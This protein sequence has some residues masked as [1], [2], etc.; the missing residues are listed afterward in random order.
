LVGKY[1][2]DRYVGAISLDSQS[3]PLI[4]AA[5]LKANEFPEN[6]EN[7]TASRTRTHMSPKVK[8]A[9]EREKGEFPQP[10]ELST[11]K[12]GLKRAILTFSWLFLN[13]RRLSQRFSS[14]V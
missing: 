5:N 13:S 9:V 3:R 12:R 8:R 14:R 1:V 2:L 4:F 11:F 6:L 10:L 7:S